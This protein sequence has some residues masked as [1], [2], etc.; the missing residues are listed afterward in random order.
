MKARKTSGAGTSTSASRRSR[1]ASPIA[2]ASAAS[3]GQPAEP[4]GRG[5]EVVDD[6][7]VGREPELAAAVAR[8]LGLVAEAVAERVEVEQRERV[9]DH[10]ADQRQH[11][12][13]QQAA[14]PRPGHGRGERRG[15][16]RQHEDPGRVLRRAGD[17]ERE[18]GDRV[19]A[20][21]V[22][23]VDRRHAEQREADGRERRRVVERQVRVVH[24]QERDGQ[25]RARDQPGRPADQ[26]PPGPGQQR[27]RDA[28]RGARRRSARPRTRSC[29]RSPSPPPPRRG[30]R[31]AGRRRRAAGTCRRAG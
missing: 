11:A 10:E 4:P 18:A 27:D 7:A 19:A 25:Q 20:V 5:A 8:G 9:G 3:A 13:E 26:P 31:S 6:P 29:G 14:E 17:A 23:A 1:S 28:C 15:G 16:D 22:V 21:A 24:G 30:R 12:R 2:P